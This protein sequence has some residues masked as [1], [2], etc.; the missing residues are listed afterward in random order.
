MKYCLLAFTVFVESFVLAYLLVPMVVRI[1]ERFNV[2]DK[3]GAR[4]VHRT[5]KPLLGGVAIFSGFFFVLVINIFAFASFHQ[6]EKVLQFLP[7][8]PRLFEHLIRVLPQLLII[9][10]GGVM[11]HLL[12]LV[13]D[14]YK[15]KL[16]YKPKFLIQFA[17]ALF[18]TLA[19][20]RTNLMPG[21]ALDVAVSVFWIIGITNSFNLLDNLDG[22]TAGVT[23]IAALIFIAVAIL[24]GQIFIALILAAL[25]GAAAGFW[26]HNFH[27]SRLF[28]GDS[29]SLFIGYMFGVLTVLESYVV[30]SSAS[31]LPVV[32]PILIL[33]IPL[34]DTL[35][36]MIIR[37]REKRPLFIGDKRHFS[38]RLLDLGMNHRETVVFIYLICFGVGLAATLLP[39]VT[40]AGSLV[41]V[42]QALIV[43]ALITILIRV[44]KRRTKTS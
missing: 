12:G 3:P 2:V 15:E 36:V 23:V 34:Y 10:L 6:Q 1:A 16:T 42:I 20:I 31:L 8:A 11:M 4:K 38:H 41:L 17:I 40:L 26:P 24:Q 28:M 35:S 5:S 30:E 29:G 43:Y 9:L 32:M 44:G 13:D 39:Y 33:S 19:G 37:L 7:S 27:P 14:I 18:V 25:A 21:N 22:L